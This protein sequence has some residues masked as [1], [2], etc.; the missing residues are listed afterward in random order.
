MSEDFKNSIIP[1]DAFNPRLVR[2]TK[3]I[4]KPLNIYQLLKRLELLPQDMIP[5]FVDSTGE[6]FIITSV[7]YEDSNEV[8]LK[9]VR[10]KEGD[11]C[12]R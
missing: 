3:I 7:M 10:L 8:A 4:A 6:E 2:G 9:I 12:L 11:E 1:A 5:K